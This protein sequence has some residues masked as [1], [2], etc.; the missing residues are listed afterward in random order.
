M[1]ALAAST[2]RQHLAGLAQWQFDDTA[3]ALT[4][5][6]VFADFNAAFAFMT[7]VSLAAEQRNHHPDWRNV[8]NRVNITLTTHEAGGITERDLDFARWIDSILPPQQT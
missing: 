5:H 7:R 4:R 8:Y 1:Q 6:L 3:Q 2:V